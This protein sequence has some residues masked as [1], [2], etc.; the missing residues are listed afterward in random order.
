MWAEVANC[1][2]E[3]SWTPIRKSGSEWDS[4]DAWKNTDVHLFILIW[5]S[6]GIWVYI[7][8][9]HVAILHVWVLLV[10]ILALVSH[11]LVV[12]RRILL[13][14]KASNKC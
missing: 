12:L 8:Q 10:T 7:N 1:I 14:I 11:C 9:N 6:E 5:L 2:T 4:T 13:F 3:S